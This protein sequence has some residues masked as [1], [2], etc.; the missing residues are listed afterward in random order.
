MAGRNSL[1]LSLPGLDNKTL[2]LLSMLCSSKAVSDGIH[3]LH[4]HK[5]P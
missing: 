1:G 2:S 4:D 3:E 5:K